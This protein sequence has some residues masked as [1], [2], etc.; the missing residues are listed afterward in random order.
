[1][2]R[3]ALRI[4]TTLLSLGLATAAFAGAAG[5]GEQLTKKE[6]VKQANATCETATEGISSAFA[7]ALDGLAPNSQPPPEEAQAALA[8]AVAGAVPIFR[9]A[10]AEIEALDGPNVF[11]KKVDRLLDE[12]AAD[13]DDVEADPMLA[14]GEELF[15][16]P[17]RR[18][19][20][21]G[22]K[23]CIQNPET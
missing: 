2:R 1:M 22:M 15:T 19:R 5:A 10:L 14:V 16:R 13:L 18:A 11:E 21:L 20:R 6:F 23:E 8:A 17:D 4:T 7:A 9:T 12:Y 3:S